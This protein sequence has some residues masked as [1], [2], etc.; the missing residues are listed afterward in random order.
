MHNK[1]LLFK[2]LRDKHYFNPL[3]FASTIGHGQ[4]LAILSFKKLNVK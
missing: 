4:K 1:Y 3:K 2:I